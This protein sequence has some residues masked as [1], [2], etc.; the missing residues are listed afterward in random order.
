[1]SLLSFSLSLHIPFAPWYHLSRPLS[2]VTNQHRSIKPTRSR[3]IIICMLDAAHDEQG[4]LGSRLTMNKTFGARLVE[5]ASSI[6]TSTTWRSRSTRCA[7]NLSET[8]TR[9][10]RISFGYEKSNKY[11]H[12]E[13]KTLL[14]GTLLFWNY[15]N[16]CFGITRRCCFGITR[17]N[18][19]ITRQTTG[20]KNIQKKNE[21]KPC[22]K[23]QAPRKEMSATKDN[24]NQNQ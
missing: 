23:K 12:I 8:S 24:P 17:H 10:M 6:R 2:Q 13:T 5:E 14:L 16:C 22:Q 1:M 15:E 19:T 11:T 4:F 21:A 7:Q 9:T 18:E 20:Q 3:K